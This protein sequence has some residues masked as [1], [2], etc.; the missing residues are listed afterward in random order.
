MTSNVKSTTQFVG[1]SDAYTPP[2]NRPSDRIAEQMRKLPRVDH[3]GR[4]L[5]KNAPSDVIETVT[6]AGPVPT[7]ASALARAAELEGADLAQLLDSERFRLAVATISP[8]DS[9]GLQDAIRDYMPAPAAPTMRP[10]LAQGA[11]SAVAPGP[12]TGSTLE[13]MHDLAEKALS[14]PEPPG[15]TYRP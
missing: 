4:D 13:R 11:P 1:P 5:P 3:N 7:M 10:N 15:S 12:A 9:L 8:A 14:Q 2:A 6:P